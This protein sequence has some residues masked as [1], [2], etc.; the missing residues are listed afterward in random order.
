MVHKLKFSGK[1]SRIYIEQLFR[2]KSLFSLEKKFRKWESHDMKYEI[3]DYLFQ[4]G[5]K[6][7]MVGKEYN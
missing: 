2:S 1:G 7:S 6:E 4:E 5:Q 3:G